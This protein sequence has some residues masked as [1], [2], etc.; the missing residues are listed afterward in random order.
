MSIVRSSHPSHKHHANHT[1]IMSITRSSINSSY[2]SRHYYSHIIEQTPPKWRPGGAPWEH[3]LEGPLADT[4]PKIRHDSASI[5]LHSPPSSS[6][7]K[8]LR[9]RSLA[10]LGGDTFMSVRYIGAKNEVFPAQRRTGASGAETDTGLLWGLG[11][12]AFR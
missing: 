3:H 6:A 4:G 11:G 2:E 8:A 12:F 9:R 1:T 10:T 5:A 7:P